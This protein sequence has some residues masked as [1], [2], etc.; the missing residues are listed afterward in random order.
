MD[1]LGLPKVSMAHP[2]TLMAKAYGL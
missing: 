2:L 1:E